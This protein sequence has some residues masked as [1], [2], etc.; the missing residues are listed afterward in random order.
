[1]EAQSRPFAPAFSQALRSTISV[2][3]NPRMRKDL[4]GHEAVA[5]SSS[6]TTSS[7]AQD[8]FGTPSTSA[9]LLAMSF[10]PSRRALGARQ[11]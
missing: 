7:V 9:G 6:M 8:G 2:S 1:M 10:L 5:M 3:R 11:F 4:L